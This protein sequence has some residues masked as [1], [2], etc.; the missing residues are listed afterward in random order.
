MMFGLPQTGLVDPSFPG[1]LASMEPPFK[2]GCCFDAVASAA[3]KLMVPSS[4]VLE[5]C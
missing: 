5:E 3:L 4:R 2:V 1:P